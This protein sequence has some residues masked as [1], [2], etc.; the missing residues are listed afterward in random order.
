MGGKVNVVSKF[1]IKLQL[2]DIIRWYKM[3]YV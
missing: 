3:V 1:E 2:F